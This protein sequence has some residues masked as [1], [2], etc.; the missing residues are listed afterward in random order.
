MTSTKYILYGIMV[1]CFAIAG[2]MDLISG[3]H[4]SGL[5]AWGFAI[6]NCMIF[7]WR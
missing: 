5:L 1:L 2:T 4:K 7:F 6:L 3:E